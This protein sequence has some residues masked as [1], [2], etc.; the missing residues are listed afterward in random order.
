MRKEGTIRKEKNNKL[1]I[2]EAFLKTNRFFWNVLPIILSTIL[3]VNLVV[4]VVPNNF[5]K[6]FFTENPIIDSLIGSMI[7]SISAGNPITSYIIGGELL[8]EGVSLVAVT[9]FL[10]A[11]VTVGLIQ[12]PA[13]SMLLGRKFAILRNIT[14]FILSIIVA[15]ITVFIYNLV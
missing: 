5:Y 6:L 12:L 9:S 11:W 1:K 2:K 8:N 14:A 15:I 13:E 7:G 3:L 4:S 10:V